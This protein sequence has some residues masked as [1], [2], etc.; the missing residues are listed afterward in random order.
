M[1]LSTIVQTA[2]ARFSVLLTD[3]TQI[4]AYLVQALT[5]Y[6]D[7][8][9][10]LRTTVIDAPTVEALT[11]PQSFL[12][13]SMCSDVYGD[14]VPVEV[15]ELE[16]GTTT[17]YMPAGTIYPV[18]Y[19]F[20]VNLAYYAAD[21]ENHIPNRIAGMVTDYLECLIATDND[22]RIARIEAGGKMDASR[23][24]TRLDRMAQKTSLE[25]QFRA[26]RAIV[27]MASIHPI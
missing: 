7:L 25:E 11:L 2:K 1:K 22:D 10:C 15:L 16:D 3:D 18:K 12:A 6:Q 21:L 23:M 14:F 26:N 19:E 13:H 8:A 17:I 5:T 9:G 27:S 24:P 20:L 4:S